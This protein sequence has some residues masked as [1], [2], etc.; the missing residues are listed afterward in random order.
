MTSFFSHKRRSNELFVYFR[1]YALF[2]RPFKVI[3]VTGVL[4]PVWLTWLHETVIRKWLRSFLKCF[5]T[6]LILHLL[7]MLPWSMWS[8]ALFKFLWDC[9]FAPRVNYVCSYKRLNSFIEAFNS[10]YTFV[11]HVFVFSENNLIIV[12]NINSNEINICK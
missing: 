7:Y 11:R 10:W 9:R 5:M 1:L 12:E 4:K 3:N 8:Y 6:Y 2:W